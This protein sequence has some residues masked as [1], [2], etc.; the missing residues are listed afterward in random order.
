MENYQPD[1]S[2]RWYQRCTKQEQWEYRNYLERQGLCLAEW[3]H[4]SGRLVATVRKINDPDVEQ[5][6]TLTWEGQKRPRYVLRG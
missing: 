2:D 1:K 5:R 3:Q 6:G 4:P